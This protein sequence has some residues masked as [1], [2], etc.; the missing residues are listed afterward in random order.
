MWATR[1]KY[2]PHVPV[3]AP[4]AIIKVRTPPIRRYGEGDMVGADGPRVTHEHHNV[5]A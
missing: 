4:Q 5:Y 2:Y 1:H 3:T